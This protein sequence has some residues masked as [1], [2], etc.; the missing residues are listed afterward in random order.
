MDPGILSKE[1][2]KDPVI[3]TVIHY[4]QGGW[5]LGR[6]HR[7]EDS[8]DEVY[9]VD[10]FKKI[11]DS[12]STVDGCLFYGARVVVPVTLQKQVL[13]ILHLGHFGMQ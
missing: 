12:L 3:S 11:Q 7:K 5:P 2:A 13:Q 6:Q 8:R 9:T 10:A 1:S 4:T